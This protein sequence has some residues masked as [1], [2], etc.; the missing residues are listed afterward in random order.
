MN[1]ISQLFHTACDVKSA[2][3]GGVSHEPWTAS[4]KDHVITSAPTPTMLFSITVFLAVLTH[5]A[6]LAIQRY[7]KMQADNRTP[8]PFMRL[9]PELRDMV[10]SYLIED[11]AYPPPP[12]APKQTSKL[13]WM[14]PT[15]WHSVLL[16]APEPKPSNWLLLA[17]KQIKKEYSDL[18]CKRATFHLTISPQNY[19]NPNSISP[20]TRTRH[21]IWNIDPLTL[22]TLRSCDLQLITTSNML[23]VTDP[24]NMT[25]SEWTLAHQIRQD[26]TTL[27]NVKHFTLEA[28]AIGDPLWNPLWIWYHAC[29][30]FKNMG[31]E[32]SDT[33]PEG[34]RLRK[35]TF[36]LDTW[37]P[38]ENYL[39]R[40]KAN[41]GF[42]TWYCK[43]GHAVGLDGEA[44]REVP[45]REFCAKLYQE[46]R[47]CS[48]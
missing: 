47:V 14:L 11:P 45:V 24:R 42:W 9:P 35:I 18:I 19:Q 31:T 2:P 21:P 28:K 26:L 5:I 33:T 1:Y 39:E 20:T 15:P 13:S 17:S 27:T 32:L 29:Q 41:G 34:P 6:L 44:R 12:P 25:S 46:C 30:S 36:S 10:Y 40:D 48:G 43:E 16:T 7:Q 23:G 37:S 4:R 3:A 22:K 8:F 38:G